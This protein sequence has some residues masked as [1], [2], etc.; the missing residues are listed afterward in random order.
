MNFHRIAL[1]VAVLAVPCSANAFW[2]GS[3]G[4]CGGCGSCAPACSSCCGSSSGAAEV[5]A[6]SVVASAAFSRMV[7]AAAAVAAVANA[8]VSS[9]G[10]QS[11]GCAHESCGVLESCGCGG[12][13]KEEEQERARSDREQADEG[14][15]VI[16]FNRRSLLLAH[17]VNGPRDPVVPR[18]ICFYPVGQPF[19][20]TRRQECPQWVRLALISDLSF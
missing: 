12:E 16:G 19:P 15:E 14:K 7:A 4:S 20:P 9:C 13:V 18:A 2:F 3:N 5:M 8:A 10:C 6:A 1:I 11:C 17:R